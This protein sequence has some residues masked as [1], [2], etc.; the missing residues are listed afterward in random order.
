MKLFISAFL[1]F[2]SSVSMGQQLITIA[3]IYEKGT[4]KLNTVRG[5]NWM[6]DG[7]YYTSLE[8]QN[9]VQYNVASG[10]KVATLLNGSTL[11][12]QIT[13]SNYSFSPNENKLLLL[14]E[15]EQIYRR[16]FKGEYFVYDR[17][18]RLLT[19]L[20][21]GG[22][23]SY[24]TF[25]PDGSMVAFVRNN[26]LYYTNLADRREYQITADGKFNHVI[27][28]STDWVY[29]EEFGFT[30]GFF[31][32]PDSKRIAYYRFDESEVKEYNM[33]KWNK[34]QLYPTDYRFKYPKAGEQNAKVEIHIY[35]L[36]SHTTLKA[37]LGTS[38]DDYI[39]RV[40]WTQN[41]ILLSV[42]TLN[43]LQNEMGLLHVNAIDGSA[44]KIL[45]ETSN[46]YVDLAY[47]DE[48]IYLK[49]REHFLSTSERDGNKHLYQYG[50]DGKLVRQV[51]Q[52]PWE[53]EKLVGVDES[54]RNPVLYYVSTEES[55]LE[56]HFYSIRMHGK[57]K[58]KLTVFTGIHDINMSKDASYYIDYHSNSE[59]PLTVTLYQTKGNAT[60]KELENNK[61]LRNTV[62]QF[63]VQPKEYFTF[64]TQDSVL[65]HGYLIK[66]GNLDPSKEYPVLIYQYSGPGSQQVKNDWD[67]RNFY[68]HQM[69]VQK[70]Y[71]VAVMDPRGTGARG[72]GF[73]KTTYK[74]L[75]KL[76]VE[77][78]LAGVRYLSSL[79]FVDRERIGI[80]GWSY[81]GYIA[82]L[83][84]M[85]G[86]DIFRAGIAVAPVTNWRFYDTIYT[87]RYLQRPRDNPLG[88]DDN[89]PVNHAHNLRS[90]FLLIHG[91]GDDNVHLQN[92]MALSE[93]LITA[94]KPFESFYYPD[95]AHAI[96]KDQARRHLFEKMTEFILRNL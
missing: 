39:P 27:N 46:T 94:N 23:Q 64:P 8:G 9:I 72:A 44:K 57:E 31:W 90:K 26:N 5:I 36:S 66:P 11:S 67:G 35:Q 12:P 1:L 7:G 59:Q 19:R 84:L 58:K 30:K 48:L 55:P 20:S 89:S 45:S 70:G 47:C 17:N 93:A 54:K 18:A 21:L 65:L 82:S 88:Y 77:D 10:E 16:S 91:T 6:N 37:D 96:R 81:G 71:I 38:E 25:S 41:P 13:F 63:Q 28:G 15:R 79:P 42:R 87:E 24:A 60:I 76:E 34:G 40:K 61:V 50:M 53:V 56:R 32:S 68:W 85:K 86:G 22:A 33:Q 29:E 69:L 73:K 51:T 2:I 43:R 52:G 62:Q 80:W 49:D 3:D 4:F 83:A 95:R 74:Q 75:G 92:S 78:L 14:T